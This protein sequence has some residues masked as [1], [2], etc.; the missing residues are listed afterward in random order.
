MHDDFGHHAG[1]EEPEKTNGEAEASPVMS[2][3][4]DLESVSIEVDLAVEVHLVES[5][6]WDLVPAPVFLSVRL[7]LE[8]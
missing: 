8:G 7:L 4:H 6:H 2:V 3:F 5:L 1:Q